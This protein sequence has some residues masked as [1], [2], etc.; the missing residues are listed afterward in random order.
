MIVSVA[1]LILASLFVAWISK[2][3]RLPELVGLLILG[4]ILGPHLLNW[5]DPDLLS[6]SSDLRM[7]ALLV[8]LLRAG[9][10]LSRDTLNR[11]GRTALLLS[12]VPAVFEGAVIALIS[13]ALLGL[14]HLEGAL[15][16]AII[17][18]VSPA[19][20]VP[21]MLRFV[22]ENRGNKKGIPTLVLA[23]SSI[24]D[25][26]VIVVFSI[27]LGIYT[28]EKVNLIW[29]LAG[30]PISIIL[31]IVIGFACAIALYRLFDRFNPR[32]TKRLLIL[33]AVGVLI[34]QIEHLTQKWVPFSG[35]LAVMA[36]GFW[37]LEKREAYAHELSGKLAKVWV[38]A[39]II[40]FTMVGAQVDI[41][42]AF[43]TGLAGASV[44]LIGL[45]ARNAGTWLCLVRSGLNRKEKIFVIL[46][47]IPK[48]TVQA[49][50]GAA[51]LVALQAAGLST[52][53]GETILAVA[54]LSIVLTAPLGSLAIVW[55]GKRALPIET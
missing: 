50:I 7:T 23:A 17:A 26:F 38:I 10:E 16:G 47:Y 41:G 43:R 49:A 30:I 19:V 18:A 11:V 21:F 40:L 42:V 29:K 4:V 35:L 44:I 24:D 8:I 51:P 13:P 37:I 53:P 54:V 12:F 32:A 27:L 9:L 46:S 36:I 3:I 15:L 25:V 22:D 1:G 28:G 34:L 2:L 33:I 39:E 52:A 55:Y 20:V 45:I 5:L 14:T 6:I 31:G 48:A